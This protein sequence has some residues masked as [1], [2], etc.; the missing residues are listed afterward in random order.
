MSSTAIGDSVTPRAIPEASIGRLPLYLRALVDM[1]ERDTHTVS[2]ET[3]AAA[4]GVNSAKIRKDL[5]YLGSY[6]T[7]GVGYDVEYLIHQISRE[8]GLTQDWSVVI[9]GIGHLGKALANYSGFAERGF[10]IA[11]LLD[12]DPSKVGQV[13][14]GVTVTHIDEVERIVK[15]EEVSI[16]ILAVPAAVAQEACDRL[17]SAGITSIMNFAPVV[18]QV[19]PGVSLR[20][21][22]L[23]IELQ[24]LSFY[25]QRKVAE[26]SVR[27]GTARQRLQQVEGG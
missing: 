21:V 12:A 17:C 16:A 27:H 1:A 10:R 2:S 23:S 22:D 26:E 18:L 14:G 24:I 20:K 8:L 11:S 6:G 13:F 9:V 15:E 3:L 4:S 19:P 7:R 5:S 25:E